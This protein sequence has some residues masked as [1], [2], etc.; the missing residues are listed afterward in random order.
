MCL[1]PVGF[2]R[3]KTDRS[4]QQECNSKGLVSLRRLKSDL[5]VLFKHHVG[6]QRFRIEKWMLSSKGL[7]APLVCI[8]LMFFSLYQFFI[9]D[10]A[11]D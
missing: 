8:V 2:K 7:R 9:S 1:E 11:A 4:L 10:S 3:L 5:D 6:K